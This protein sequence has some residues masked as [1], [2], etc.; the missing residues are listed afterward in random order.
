VV[1]PRMPQSAQGTERDEFTL[2]V[3]LA[4]TLLSAAGIAVPDFMQGRDVS[5]LYMDRRNATTSAGVPPPSSTWRDDFFYE[6]VQ[7][8]FD[9][10]YIPSALALVNRE[11]KYFYWPQTQY[12][13]LFR[14]S[15]DPYEED[16]VF[17]ATDPDLL[18]TIKARFEQLKLQS[19][20]GDPV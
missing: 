7:E 14:V 9:V 20:R 4:P 12:E 11:Y 18:N 5:D 17:N 19:Q 3:D 1:D 15:D 10:S 8:D 2:S 13:Q 6:F 16:D